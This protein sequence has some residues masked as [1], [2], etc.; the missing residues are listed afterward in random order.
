M[1]SLLF[2]LPRNSFK[3]YLHGLCISLDVRE[4]IGLDLGFE[5]FIEVTV[6][7]ICR[8]FSL[9]PKRCFGFECYVDGL[10]R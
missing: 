8:F 2:T 10:L 6:N 1:Y 4:F 7:G 5:I 9:S 3:K